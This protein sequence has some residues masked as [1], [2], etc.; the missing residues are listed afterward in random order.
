MPYECIRSHGM[1]TLMSLQGGMLA[2]KLQQALPECTLLKWQ[3]YCSER[4]FSLEDLTS[5]EDKQNEFK[6]HGKAEKNPK[7]QRDP[8][9]RPEGPRGCPPPAT[10]PCAPGARQLGRVGRGPGGRRSPGPVG[11][12]PPRGEKGTESPGRHSPPGGRSSGPACRAGR[13]SGSA[14]PGSGRRGGGAGPAAARRQN[15]TPKRAVA[16]R[17]RK[18]GHGEEVN[19]RRRRVGNACGCVRS[20]AGG[21]PGAPGGTP[22]SASALCPGTGRRR[23]PQCACART[24]APRTHQAPL[25]T[26]PEVPGT[27]PPA[28]A[29]RN[30]AEEFPPRFPPPTCLSWTVSGALAASRLSPN[31]PRVFP[32]SAPAPLRDGILGGKQ[33]V[34]VRKGAGVRAT[35]GKTQCLPWAPITELGGLTVDSGQ[36]LGAGETS[37]DEEAWI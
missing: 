7:S 18:R 16:T 28:S 33:R 10:A 30:Q 4:R 6:V 31:R 9:N 23:R 34:P 11:P 13:R 22:C 1:E 35:P 14:A 29:P 19:L 5:A 21:S 36:S 25:L 27:G 24:R 8:G 15:Q 2:F 12:G 3:R 26:S 17:P 37:R 20:P 32:V